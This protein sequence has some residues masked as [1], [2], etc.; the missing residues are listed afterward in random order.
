MKSGRRPSGSGSYESLRRN[1]GISGGVVVRW[2]T[3]EANTTVHEQFV[4]FTE[5]PVDYAPP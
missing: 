5:A 3:G 2:I 1:C 4:S